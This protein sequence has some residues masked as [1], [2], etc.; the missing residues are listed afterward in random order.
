MSA[1]K[2][3]N[4]PAQRCP[5]M[6]NAHKRI[7]WR[8]HSA[9]M[10]ALPF[11]V[12]VPSRSPVRLF[13]HFCAQTPSP[14]IRS[15]LSTTSSLR[16]SPARTMYEPDTASEGSAVTRVRR[17]EHGRMLTALSSSC[18]VCSSGYEITIQPLVL[19]LF[20]PL[21]SCSPLKLRLHD[22]RRL[23]RDQPG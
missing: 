23:A 3:A 6:D 15:F 1:C 21:C 16:R 7:E 14:P 17:R 12:R 10:P 19:Y 2:H 5:T 22:H 20:D 8:G 11:T 18:L 13:A 4:R 9:P